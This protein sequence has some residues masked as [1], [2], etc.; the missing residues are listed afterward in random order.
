MFAQ[1]SNAARP[2]MAEVVVGLDSILT[3]QQK[4]NSALQG[5]GKTVIGRMLDM[6]PFPSRG[7]NSDHGESKL[8]SNSKDNSRNAGSDTV[9]DKDLTIPIPSLKV[10]K[11]GDLEMASRNF[12]Q[13]LLL[14]GD[15]YKELFLG[16]VD[17]HT[18]APSKEGVGIPV[19]IRRY[20]KDRQDWQMHQMSP[21]DFLLGWDDYGNVFLGWVDKKTFTPST[22]GV[23]IAVAVKHYNQGRQGW[24]KITQRSD[25]STKTQERVTFCFSVFLYKSLRF[26]PKTLPENAAVLTLDG[27]ENGICAS[28][29]FNYI[30]CGC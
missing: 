16:W 20:F 14:G 8:S 22:K 7:E 27:I 10:F 29:N 30:E 17:S 3:L 21:Q 24:Q 12:S 19:A 4:I 6:L 25:L 18:F 28:G 13:D 15:G 23:G 2:T 9:T 11:F 1:Q 26:S 5:K